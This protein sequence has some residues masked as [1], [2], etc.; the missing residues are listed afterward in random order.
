M[1]RFVF[2]KFIDEGKSTLLLQNISRYRWTAE[3]ALQ[4]YDVMPYQT[5]IRTRILRLPDEAKPLEFLQK[6]SDSRNFFANTP[7]FRTT[8]CYFAMNR[9]AI[10]GGNEWCVYLRAVTRLVKEARPER[11]GSGILCHAYIRTVEPLYGVYEIPSDEK[12]KKE[13]LW[14][15]RGR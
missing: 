12:T 3:E 9:F 8:K 14:D 6:V 1:K 4:R 5:R 10:N 2:I 13:D 15:I 11:I 7:A